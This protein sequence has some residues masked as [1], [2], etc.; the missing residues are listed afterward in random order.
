MVT[1]TTTTKLDRLRSLAGAWSM[2][3]RTLGADADDITGTVTIDVV[4]D[5]A[6]MALRGDQTIGDMHFQTL[7]VIWYDADTHELRSHVYSAGA[8]QPLDYR[9]DF[10]GD[11]FIHA[12]MG[13]T[14]R[15]TLSD[16]E[17]ILRGGW[18]PDPGSDAPAESAYDVTMVRIY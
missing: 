1:T 16:D 4:A 15:G 7:E 11:T 3:G 5:G 8:D 6:V 17:M 2:T 10:D 18:R 14:Y 12:G 13:S 9:W